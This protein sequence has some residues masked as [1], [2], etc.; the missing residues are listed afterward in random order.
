MKNRNINNISIHNLS[1]E[2]LK[3]RRWSLMEHYKNIKLASTLLSFA[4]FILGVTV[5][6]WT[7]YQSGEIGP[8]TGVAMPFLAIAA[9]GMLFNGFAVGS[10]ITY[11][12]A[13]WIGHFG[14]YGIGAASF[15]TI[16]GIVVFWF[17][18]RFATNVAKETLDSVK[19]INNLLDSKE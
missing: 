4:W 8:L 19:E 14:F 13:I 18:A 11:A 6:A 5:P 15:Y 7:S 10:L 3:D 16:I 12:L 9:N 1:V 2:G 17:T